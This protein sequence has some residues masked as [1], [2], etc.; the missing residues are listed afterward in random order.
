MLNERKCSV[1][2]VESQKNDHHLVFPSCLD[3]KD[4]LS[5]RTEK[6][7]LFSIIYLSSSYT[8]F[9]REE[10][11]MMK[12]KKTTTTTI[13]TRELSVFFLIYVNACVHFGRKYH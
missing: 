9:S 11:K 2:I 5:S 4:N 10:K 12:K 8:S 3:M 1:V 7:K 13:K 6:K